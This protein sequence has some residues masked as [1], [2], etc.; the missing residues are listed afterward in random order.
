MKFSAKKIFTGL[1]VAAMTAAMSV[2]VSAATYNE[3]EI[4]KTNNPPVID[5]TYN[6]AEGWGDPIVTIGKDRTGYLSLCAADHPEFLTDDQL[7][8]S[9]VD[10]YMRWDDEHLYYCAVVDV[11]THYNEKKAAEAASVWQHSSFNINFKSA[12]ESETACR[13]LMGVNSKGEVIVCQEKIEDN[14]SAKLGNGN[15]PG[16]LKITRAGTITT[17][18]MSMDWKQ[19]MPGG[20]SP[21]VGSEICIRDLLMPA[22]SAD[23]QNPVDMDFAGITE[24]GSYNYWAVELDKAPAN[25]TVPAPSTGSDNVETDAPAT[26]DAAILTAAALA[27]AAG[28][29]VSKKRR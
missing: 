4:D 28:L 9:S 3:T 15:F 8:P 27:S 6:A 29:V 18:E 24:D 12:R 21:D 11:P 22:S 5:G 20:G 13:L 26:V 7:L 23:F 14:T 17:Y 10:V 19:I 16:D 25:E 1:L 2:S